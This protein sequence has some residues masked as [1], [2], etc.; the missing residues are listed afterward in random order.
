M[1]PTFENFEKT[2]AINAEIAE[3]REALNSVEGSRCECYQRI[4]GY[5][6]NVNQ[7]NLGAKER[8][9]DT[10]VFKCNCEI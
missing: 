8:W 7:W 9:K 3:L 2:E 6:R 4:V 10:K 1:N 5:H